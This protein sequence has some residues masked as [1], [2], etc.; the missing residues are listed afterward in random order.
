MHHMQ[1]EFLSQVSNGDIYTI[2]KYIQTFD[3]IRCVKYILSDTQTCFWYNDLSE[4]QHL[5]V[6]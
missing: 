6:V 3:T 2:P 1:L 5:F 4:M